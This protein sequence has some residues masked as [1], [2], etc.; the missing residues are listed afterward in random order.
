MF[1]T[2]G[3]GGTQDLV[4]EYLFPGETEFRQGVVVYGALAAPSLAADFNDDNTVNGLDLTVWKGAFGAGAAGDADGDSDSDGADFLVWQ[5][6]FGM[7]VTPAAPA[8]GAVPEPATLALAWLATLSMAI[9]IRRS[10]S[11]A[12]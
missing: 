11:S 2:V 12:M 10:R 7:S 3:S 6:Q 1:K 5:R 9:G 8:V 4:F